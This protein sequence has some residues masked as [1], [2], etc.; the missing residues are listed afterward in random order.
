MAAISNGLFAHGGFRPFCATFLNFAGYAMGSIRVS[1]LSKFGVIYIMT[2]D[3]I[4]LGEDGPTHQPVEM[5]EVLRSTPNLLTLRPCDGNETVGAYIVAIKEAETPS[6]ISL[7]RQGVP[8]LKGSASDKVS[9]GGYVIHQTGGKPALV[10]IASGTEVSLAVTVAD[11][12]KKTDGID[13]TVVSMPCT[14]LFDRQ[15]IE[16]QS[17]VLPDNVPIMSIEA[18]GTNGWNKYAHATFGMQS[19]GASAPGN[20]LLKHFGFTTSNLAIRAREVLSF[21]KAHPIPS[22]VH[23]P[24]FASV[25]TH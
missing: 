9:L 23:Y 12:L 15:S 22:K 6:F 21:Y 4:G 24:R 10:L 1:A 3:S 16:Y 8:T 11:E 7:S 14:E 20:D 2:H 19:F 13:V 18:S 17:Q 25:S 5:L